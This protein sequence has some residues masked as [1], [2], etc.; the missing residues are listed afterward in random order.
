[1][2]ELRLKIIDKFRV[3]EKVRSIP[4]F[5]FLIGRIGTSRNDPDLAQKSMPIYSGCE[6]NPLIFEEEAEVIRRHF[7]PQLPKKPKGFI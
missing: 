1:M 5:Q 6:D 4:E 7:P 2:G 3:E